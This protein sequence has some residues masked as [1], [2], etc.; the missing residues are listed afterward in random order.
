M[1]WGPFPPQL[2]LLVSKTILGSGRCSL[3]LVLIYFS[4]LP[5][6]PMNVVNIPYYLPLCTGSYGIPALRGSQSGRQE[7]WEHNNIDSV[8]SKRPEEGALTSRW[9]TRGG[10]LEGL[11]WKSHSG[12]RKWHKQR[13]RSWK[14]EK[15]HQRIAG[16]LHLV[17]TWGTCR[18]ERVVRR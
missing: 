1:M 8:T 12:S 15:T 6:S 18:E 3:A 2:L 7:K 14:T 4:L 10:S 17:R 11:S 9:A 13:P 16:G 5:F